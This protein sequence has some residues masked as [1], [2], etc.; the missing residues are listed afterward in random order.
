MVADSGKKTTCSNISQA[1]FNLTSRQLLARYCPIK[2][3]LMD[4]TRVG[5]LWIVLRTINSQMWRRFKMF[6]CCNR[7]KFSQRR[8]PAFFYLLS[9]LEW[10]RFE[11]SLFRESKAMIIQ[12]IIP[13]FRV[14]MADKVYVWVIPLNKATGNLLELIMAASLHM[15]TP[16]SFQEEILALC[17]M[18]FN[19]KSLRCFQNL[20]WE[21]CPRFWVPLGK[22]EHW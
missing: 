6:I 18:L 9:G 11:V 7:H 17:F 20:W 8:I 19:S 1:C 16:L 21:I 10:V 13:A 14:Q 12:K 22:K 4:F 5:C 2:C 15:K 3:L